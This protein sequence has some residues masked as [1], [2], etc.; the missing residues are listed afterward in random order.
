MR[1]C[2]PSSAPTDSPVRSTLTVRSRSQRFRWSRLLRSVS[3]ILALVIA[4]TTLTLD[5]A[6]AA[7]TDPGQAQAIPNGG[8]FGI[9]AKSSYEQAFNPYG[10]DWSI[11]AA[12][13]T[14]IPVGLTPACYRQVPKSSLLNGPPAEE[15]NFIAKS[16]T[17][18]IWEECADVID[19]SGPDVTGRVGDVRIKANIAAQKAARPDLKYIGYLA[20]ARADT[21][22]ADGTTA[23]I[24]L[25]YIVRNREDWF[26]HRAGTAPTPENRVLYVQEPSHLY[27]VTNPE[28]R[29]FMVARAV[30]SLNYHNMDGFVL[31][32]CFD[33]PTVKAGEV[34]PQNIRDNWGASCLSLLQELKTALEANGKRIYFTGYVHFG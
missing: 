7:P 17:P 10:D 23:A 13:N 22:V 8:D 3:A 27:D 20:L 1:S 14:A 32:Q 9:R 26:V 21:H 30:E 5:A 16:N 2:P 11:K 4:S 19:A 6:T 15:V 18:L 12:P 33:L 31:D 28:F 25:N 29:A 24:G 34:V